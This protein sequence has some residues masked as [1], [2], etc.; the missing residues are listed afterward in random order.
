MKPFATKGWIYY[1]YFERIFPNG[2]AQGLHAHRLAS[3]VSCVEPLGEE[4]GN[5]VDPPDG[6][7]DGEGTTAM[8]DA[9]FSAAMSAATSAASAAITVI[10]TAHSDMPRARL[11]S[12]NMRER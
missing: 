12:L 7:Q 5:E 3:T 9:A 6:S 2:Q 10:A 1:G 4:D 8:A 11:R